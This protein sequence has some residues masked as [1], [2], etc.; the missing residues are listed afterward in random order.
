MLKAILTSIDEGIH[1]VGSDGKTVFYNEVAAMLD[2]LTVEEV[3]KNHV[4]DVFPSLTRETSTLLKVLQTGEPIINQEQTYTNRN[5]VQINTINSTL[6][7]T[8][9]GKLIGAVEVAKDYTKIRRLSE[10]LIDLQARNMK[11]SK[12]PNDETDAFFSFE[13]IITAD[14]QMQEVIATGKKVSGTSSPLLIYGETG[15]GKEMLVQAVHN[16]SNR[17]NKPFIA[18]NCAAIPA[19]LLEGILF[20]TTKGSFTGSIDRPGLFELADRGTLFLD[21]LNSMPLEIQAKLLRVLQDGIVYRVGAVK[22]KKVDVRVTAALNEHPDDCLKNKTLRNDLYYR[23]N[24]IYLELPP[25]RFRK[26]DVLMLS[27]HFLAEYESAFCKKTK[28]FSADADAAFMN[29]E[30]RGNVR[31]LKHAVEYAMNML[32]DNG[33]IQIEHLPVHIKR[34]SLD[35]VKT[36]ESNDELS[37]APLKEAVHSYEK[38]LISRAVEASGGNIQQAARLLNIPRQ[39]LQYKLKQK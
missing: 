36:E 7:V 3:G 38:K 20:G 34:N 35:S 4:L 28:G 16:H 1:A 6:P 5:G 23:L 15:T 10:K 2:G 11:G 19:T 29:H 21:E 8:V 32:E 30:W 24:V 25:L 18:Q 39:T 22:G 13:H 12:N 14:Q 26:N 17:R 9:G 37:A 33:H 31:E 27:R